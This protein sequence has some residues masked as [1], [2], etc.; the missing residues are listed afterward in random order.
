MLGNMRRLHPRG[1]AN[2]GVCVDTEGAM[3]GPDCVLVHRTTGGFRGLARNDAAMLQKC[4]LDADRDED[5]LFRQSQRIADALNKGEIALAQIYGLHIPVGELSER[6]LHRLALA[7]FAK[8]GFDPAEPRVPAGSGRESGQWTNGGGGGGSDASSDDGGGDGENDGGGDGNGGDQGGSTTS[9]GGG[10]AAG[11]RTDSGAGGSSIST[12]NPPI[13]WDIEPLPNTSSGSAPPAVSGN[14]QP[15]PPE[16]KD[17]QHPGASTPGPVG[18]GSTEEP[19]PPSEGTPENS[20]PQSGRAPAPGGGEGERPSI[21]WT[22]RIPEQEPG[23][24][25][26]RNPI[27][28]AIATWLGRAIAILGPAFVSDPRVRIAIAAIEAASWVLQYWTEIAS[29][30]DSPKTL[31]ELQRAVNQEREG[32]QVHHIVEAQRRSNNPESNSERF[33]A[34]LE[35]R[36]NLVRIPYWKHVEISTWYSRP[37][38]DYGFLSPR[39]YLRGKSWEEQYRVGLSTLRRFGVLR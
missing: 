15:R 20:R 1:A 23:R 18:A 33:G 38:E 16:G 24:P 37:N 9:G 34:R 29:Y 35:T 11:P 13:K 5:W 3:L 31:E 17:E 8:D 10:A 36:E 25:K 32:Y 6:Q 4:A 27:I 30:L 14:N 19:A 28:R 12:D 39:D 22:I 2:R 7:P 26:Q 21:D